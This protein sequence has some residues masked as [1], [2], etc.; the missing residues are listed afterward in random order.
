MQ[1]LA[2]RRRFVQGRARMGKATKVLAK[3][4]KPGDIAVI[5]HQDLDQVAAAALLRAGV[6][7]VINCRTSLSG[8]Y[9]AQG[10][11]LLVAAG[12]A[13]IDQVQPD[14]FATLTDG[15]RISVDLDRGLVC[16]HRRPVARGHLLHTETI[17]RRLE[18]ARRSLPVELERFL[19]NTLHYARQEKDR[20]LGPIPVP[21]LRTQCRGRHVLIVVRGDGHQDDLSILD[22]YIRT[23]KPVRVGVDGA[24]DALL[25]AGWRPHLII[26]DMDSVSDAALTC[27][28][29]LVVHGYP[30]GGA[31]GYGRLQRLGLAGHIFAVPGTSEDAAFLLA[32]EAGAELIVAIGT[33]THAVDFLDKGRA[34]MASTL[35]TRLKLGG[36]LIDAKGV[37]RLYDT[38]NYGR[39]VPWLFVAALTSAGS[40]MMTAPLVNGFVR[41]AWLRMR[42]F[43][44]F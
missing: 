2:P 21:A 32:A 44:G 43:L 24:A 22:S 16:R 17:E 10:A 25:A 7:C 5:D 20:F 18:Q 31:P 29:E 34:G 23:I 6:R 30:G 19:E 39:Y 12:I 11:A 33:H 42:L 1:K 15:D 27:G 3:Q 35:L 37:S 9:P 14:P 41:A 40:I 38:Q 4:L 13:V 8:R 36:R 26:G 28:A